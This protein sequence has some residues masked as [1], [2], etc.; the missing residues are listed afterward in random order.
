M[1]ISLYVHFPF[2]HN[3]CHYCDF[4]KELHDKSV[5]RK[6][7]SALHKEIDI[8]AGQLYDRTLSTI[9]IGGG[10]P[11][12]TNLDSF[13][14]F[15]EKIKSNFTLEDNLEFSIECNPESVDR[16]VLTQLKE[17]GITR[18]TFGLQ[19]FNNKMLT[20]LGRRHNPH[21][22][23]RAVYFSNALGYKT[24]GV[25]LIFG[26]P[27]QTSQMLSDDIDQ[28]IDLDPPHISFYQ[29]TIEDGTMLYEQ[30]QA[31]KI[32][33]LEPELVLA[34]YKSGCEKLID[35]GYTRYEICSFAKPGHECR[36]NI[37]YWEGTDYLGLGPSAHSFINGQ[38]FLNWANLNDYISTLDKNELPRQID[39]S[40]IEERM[41]ET[42]LLGLR[43]M[44]GINRKKFRKRFDV[45]LDDRIDMKQYEM[46]LES[47]HLVDEDDSLKLTDEGIYL[48]EDITRRLLK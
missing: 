26:I 24:F 46:L 23:Q 22:S 25:D 3:K 36:H 48:V 10:T 14:E 42:I 17:I 39:E 45:N 44:W 18:P 1:S 41:T 37:G 33:A 30:L 43:T 47:G 19:T 27:Q 40:G 13:S 8:A 9:F 2:C 11:S 31:G 28:I 5:E 35:A 20:M 7:Y 16:D 32:K 12:L 34:M 6:F 4:Y 21:H 15:V 38:R 29:L